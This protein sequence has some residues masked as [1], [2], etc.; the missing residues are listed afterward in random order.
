[1]PSTAQRNQL[2]V[3]IDWL[4]E[5]RHHL[6]YP[7]V[8]SGQIHRTE[9]V[10]DIRS[11]ARFR[12]RVLAGVTWDCSQTVY[13]LLGAIFGSKVQNQDGATGSMLQDFPHYFDP[14]QAYIG[15]LCV[16]GP[17]PGHHVVIVRHR[18]AIHGDPICFSHGGDPARMTSL[19]TEARYQP[20][21]YV[22]LSIAHL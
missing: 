4:Y 7:P 17:A 8:Y 11:V 5:H 18:D 2:A 9:T 10:S 1:M 6:R 12:S 14:R 16:Y 3:L 21:P 13:A 22:M 20:H 15:A 19:L